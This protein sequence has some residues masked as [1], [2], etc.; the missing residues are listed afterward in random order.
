MHFDRVIVQSAAQLEVAAGVV[1]ARSG[2]VVKSIAAGDYAKITDDGICPKFGKVV[3][4]VR[5]EK[6][7]G[8]GSSWRAWVMIPTNVHASDEL[9]QGAAAA[10]AA[11][12]ETSSFLFVNNDAVDQVVICVGYVGC[13]LSRNCLSLCHR[14]LL[15]WSPRP[16]GPT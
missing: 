16:T 14:S 15:L 6:T 3:G 5:D 1:W 12:T 13:C 7:S 2:R 11:T 10:T 8:I 4:L 9:E